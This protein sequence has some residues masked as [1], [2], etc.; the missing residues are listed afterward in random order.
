MKESSQPPEEP[1]ATTPKVEDPT[2]TPKPD[3]AP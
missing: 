2:P 3:E 1:E